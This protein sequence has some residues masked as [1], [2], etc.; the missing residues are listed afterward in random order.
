MDSRREELENNVRWALLVGETI[1]MLIL[2]EVYDGT[3]DVVVTLL[4]L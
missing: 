2:S 3:Y 1:S 4:R